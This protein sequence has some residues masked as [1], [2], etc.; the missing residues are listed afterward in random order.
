MTTDRGG[1]TEAERHE[2]EATERD[3]QAE[4]RGAQAERRADRAKAER[5]KAIREWSILGLAL[6]VAAVVLFQQFHSSTVTA[7]QA[8]YNNAFALNLTQ[9]AALTDRDHE[10]TTTLIEAIAAPPVGQTRAE[11]QIYYADLFANYRR[12]ETQITVERR[13]HP[14]PQLPSK[15]C[16]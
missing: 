11:A 14:F 12:T 6:I 7:C 2:A 8:R 16:R 5:H 10:A 4:E 15:A 9:R 3:A 13:R 1:E